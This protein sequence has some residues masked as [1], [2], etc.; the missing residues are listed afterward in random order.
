MIGWLVFMTKELQTKHVVWI[1][2][3]AGKHFEDSI[4][5]CEEE[6]ILQTKLKEM[7]IPLYRMSPVNKTRD[8]IIE[9]NKEYLAQYQVILSFCKQSKERAIDISASEFASQFQG[10]FTKK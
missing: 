6:I 7:N 4:K 9:D 5:R 2:D 8:D 10:I 3:A 1:F